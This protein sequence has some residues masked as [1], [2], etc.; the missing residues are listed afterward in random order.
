MAR[1][2]ISHFAALSLCAFFGAGSLPEVAARAKARAVAEGTAT[3]ALT[4]ADL[5]ALRDIGPPFPDP[6]RHF[7]GISPDRKRIAFQVRQAN[8][9]SNTYRLSLVVMDLRKSGQPVAIDEGGELILQVVPGMSGALGETGLPETI[10]PQWSPDGNFIYFLKRLEGSTQVWRA[11]TDKLDSRPISNEGGDVGGFALSA[12]GQKIIYSTWRIEDGEREA[13]RLEGL[14]GYRYDKRFRPLTA[15][16]PEALPMGR[17]HI[18]AIALDSGRTQPASKAETAYFEGVIGDGATPAPAIAANGRR[19]WV[20]RK[21]EIGV[22]P[23]PKLFAE[24]ARRT[25]HQCIAETCAEISALW[26]RPDGTRIRYIRREGWADS[27]NAVYEWA[28]GE[29]APRRLFSTADLLLDCQPV[30]ERILC[31][32]EQSAAPRKLVLLDPQS[33]RFDTV[34]DPN[35]GFR[36]YSLGQ[37]ERLH[38][39]NEFGAETFG[40]LIYPVDFDPHRTYPLIVVQYI[41][42]GFLRGGVGDEAPIQVFANRGYAVLS[43]QRPKLTSVAQGSTTEAELERRLLNDFRDRRSVLS[44][45]EMGVRLLI[46][47]GIADRDRIGITGLSDGSSTVQFAAINSH[48]FKAGSASGCCWDPFQ[49]AFLGPDTARAFHSFGWPQLV[50]YN[51]GVWNRMSLVQNAR[52]VEFP[53]LIQQSDDEFR[54]ALASYTALQQAGNPVALFVFPGEHHIKWQPA[55]RLAVYERNIRWFDYWLKGIGTKDEWNENQ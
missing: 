27:E 48:M 35:P 1:S 22:G 54:G 9:A 8:P 14:R 5:V 50:D 30:D 18:M 36:R 34:F 12:D 37:V 53:L 15:S 4:S 31:A 3:A 24:D 6:R 38:W 21:G 43:V 26:W 32:L 45:I 10:T 29:N 40:D 46:G 39:S 16:G 51:S 19:A 33:G 42:R 49:D 28:P 17:R 41:S 47:R 11:C 7:V 2:A 13:L 23:P 25:S 20:V 52:A 55:H 44:S